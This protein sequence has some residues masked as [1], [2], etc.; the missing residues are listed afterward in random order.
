M[1]LFIISGILEDPPAAKALQ[2]ATKTAAVVRCTVSL[3]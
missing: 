2:V 3:A 1:R